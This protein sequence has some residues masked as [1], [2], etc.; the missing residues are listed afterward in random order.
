MVSNAVD[1]SG[2]VPKVKRGPGVFLAIPSL[3]AV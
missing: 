1:T 2:P 3:F